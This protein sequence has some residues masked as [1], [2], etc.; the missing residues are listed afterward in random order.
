MKDM[1]KYLYEMGQLKRVEPH[2]HICS[3]AACRAH[4]HCVCFMCKIGSAVCIP[5]MRFFLETV[6]SW[7]STMCLCRVFWSFI[8]CAITHVYKLSQINSKIRIS[9]MA[10][11]Y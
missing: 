2:L 1:A 4:F 9:F 5:E 3:E 6:K 11:L 8:L 7:N 10:L